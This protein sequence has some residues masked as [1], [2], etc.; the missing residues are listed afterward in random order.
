MT[1]AARIL[2][3]YTVAQRNKWED[4]W[5]LVEGIPF[6]MS[7]APMPKHQRIAG[8]LFWEFEKELRKCGSCKIYL[9]IDWKISKDTVFIPDLLV[10]CKPVNKNNLETTPELVVEIL[11]PSTALKDRNTKFV[12]YQQEKVK[13]YLLINPETEA[14]EIF[15][16]IE[17]AFVVAP[18]SGQYTFEFPGGCEANIS[19]GQIWD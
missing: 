18:H 19:F 15:E 17:D 16:L 8:L 13:Y 2:P 11:S 7:P 12:W 9:A 14:V 3:Y 5:E 10:T 4:P 6:A 1:S